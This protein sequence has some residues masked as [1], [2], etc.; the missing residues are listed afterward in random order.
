MSPFDWLVFI[1]MTIVFI[2]G[3]KGLPRIWTDSASVGDAVPAWWPWGS[4]AYYG[5]IRA[6]P[7]GVFFVGVGTATFVLNEFGFYTSVNALIFYLSSIPLVAALV[8]LILA[9]TVFFYNR[10]KI[11]VPPR[12]RAQ[13]GVVEA[14]SRRPRRNAT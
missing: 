7:L 1:V 10:P 14:Y 8:T 13:R 2:L 6:A 4:A 5:W 3:V 12:L 9:V 11:F